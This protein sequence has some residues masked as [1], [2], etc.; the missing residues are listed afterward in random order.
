MKK[1][2][3]LMGGSST[4]NK[5]SIKT[6]KAVAAALMALDYEVKS[7]DIIHPEW[8]IWLDEFKPD[9]VFIGLH[10]LE[11]EDG[12]IQGYLQT[13]G[14][15]YTGSGVLAS[16]LAMNKIYAQQILQSNGLP[17][18]TFTTI[19]KKEYYSESQEANLALAIKKIGFPMVVKAPSQG[20]SI[21]I[22]FCHNLQELKEGIE[23]A[24][25]YESHLLLEKMILGMEI[26]VSVL[27]NDNPFP[28]PTLEITTTTGRYDYTTKY[29][30]GM[31][32]HIIPARLPE[33]TRVLCRKMASKAYQTLGLQG[34]G[35]IDFM[36]DYAF[37]PYIL[38]ANT[39]P[40][41]TETSLIPDAA[42]YM[43]ISFEQ[44][45]ELICEMALGKEFPN[46]FRDILV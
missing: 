41:M 14:Y 29:T 22:Y 4:E 24:F 33:D 40:G 7:I 34:F 5:I 35:R 36:I 12:T 19:R 42:R 18:P 37:Q 46:H 23:L 17:V 10:G 15:A 32:Q 9:V 20:S 39:I 11:G 27:G 44:L 8:T 43:G 30:P 13:K 26:T 21:G 16:A 1:I 2:A 3:V 38:E 28:M 31:S 6:G 45:V 25:A